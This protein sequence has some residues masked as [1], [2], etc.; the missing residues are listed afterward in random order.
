MGLFAHDQFAALRVIK[1][2][3]H[4]PS[5]SLAAPAVLNR[6]TQHEPFR[7]G[8]LEW[9][10]LGNT[11]IYLVSTRKVADRIC[12]TISS[13]DMRSFASAGGLRQ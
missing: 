3:R 8:R 4:E 11:A 13:L 5:S 7:I 2:F 1:P 12:A 9:R 6:R 10:A